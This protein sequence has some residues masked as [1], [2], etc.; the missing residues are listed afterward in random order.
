ML[1][2]IGLEIFPGGRA[3]A[4]A[5]EHPGC[6][7]GGETA[8]E[9]LEALPGVFEDYTTWIH[10]HSGAPWLPLEPGEYQL[11]ETWE[12]YTIDDEY[13]LAEEGYQVNAWFLHDWKPLSIEDIKRG[14]QLLEWSHAE[15]LASAAG[16]S[17]EA[18]QVRLPGERWHVLGILAHVGGAEWW[19]LNNLGLSFPRAELPEDPDERL[20]RTQAELNRRLP[21]LAGDQLVVGVDGEFWSPRKLLRRAVWHV[22]DHT[23]HI[24]RLRGLLEAAD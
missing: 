15:L 2:R 7:A 11:E 24:N 21:L 12:V 5:L 17:P 1:F 18:R 4:W 8:D 6:F 16:L 3:L 20:A 14:R 9:A 19:Y 10:Q 23:H 13:E 22:R